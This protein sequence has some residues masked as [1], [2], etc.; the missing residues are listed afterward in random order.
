MAV[1]LKAYIYTYICICVYIHA[2]MELYM[3]LQF[4]IIE[5]LTMNNF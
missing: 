2:Y 4:D 1:H 3:L 5:F